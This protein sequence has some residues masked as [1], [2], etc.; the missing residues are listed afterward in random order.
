MLKKF[1]IERDA[2]GLG[3]LSAERIADMANKSNKAIDQ[4]GPGLQWNESYLTDNKMYCV[5]LAESED[6]IREHA[7]IGGFPIKSVKEIKRMLDPTTATLSE[8]S[9][10]QNDEDIYDSIL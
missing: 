4:L 7:R 2:D 5:Y 9:D 10:A 8:N 6:L 3:E 1:L